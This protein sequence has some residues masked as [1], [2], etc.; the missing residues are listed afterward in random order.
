M[1]RM[2]AQPMQALPVAPGSH[3]PLRRYVRHPR[4]IVSLV[5]AIIASLLLLAAAVSEVT[6]ALD[7]QRT[8]DVYALALVF[9]PL[10]IWFA[11]GQLWAQQRLSGIKLT[12]EQFPEAY[13]MLVDAAGRSGLSYVPDAYVVLGNGVINA[14]ASGHGLRRFVFINSDLVEVGG[15]A[16][17]PDA[18]R[19]VIAHEVGHIAA[20]HVSY[21]RILGT[22]ASQWIPLVGST[23]SRAQEFT[24][25][26]Y[27]H[28]LAPQGARSAMATLAG[29]KY[30]GRSVDVDAMADRAVTEPGSSSGSPTPSRATRC[31]CGASTHCATGAVPAACSGARRSRGSGA[32]RPRRGRT[33]FLPWSASSRRPSRRTPPRSSRGNPD[34]SHRRGRRSVPCRAR[35]RTVHATMTSGGSLGR[36]SD[37]VAPG[38]SPDVLGSGVGGLGAHSSPVDRTAGDGCDDTRTTLEHRRQHRDP[39]PEHGQTGTDEARRAVAPPGGQHHRAEP[40]TERVGRVERRVVEG[41]GERLTLVRD[42]HQARL[43]QRHD[44]RGQQPQDE[45]HDDGEPERVRRPAEEG[46]EHGD[47]AER[48]DD[49]LE[50]ADAVGDPPAQHHARDH[51]DAVCR[52]HPRD[53]ALVQAGEL[54]HG[55]RDEGVHREHAAEADDA[56]EQGEPDLYTAQRLHLGAHGLVAARRL[57][58][59]EDGDGHD[60]QGRDGADEDVGQVPGEPLAEQRRHGHPDDVRDP[61]AAEDG[62]HRGSTALVRHEGGSHDRADPEEGA[63]REACEEPRRHDGGVAVRREDGEVRDGKE[64][65]QA[66]EQALARDL[67]RGDGDERGPD[68]HAERVGRHVVTGRGDVDT[69]ALGDLRQQTHR[70]ELRGADGE[71][72]HG[73]REDGEGRA[74][75]GGAHRGSPVGVVRS[76]ARVVAPAWWQGGVVRIAV[77]PVSDSNGN[78][79][80]ATVIPMPSTFERLLGRL[81]GIVRGAS[82]PSRSRSRQGSPPS[83]P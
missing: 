13:A 45:D 42:V 61:E 44:D 82:A 5:V 71:T 38:G 50:H 4:E 2:R 11:R 53:V 49:A 40:G 48:A 59:Q 78:G 23:L 83:R 54:G 72:S 18:L 51:A 57:V 16:R 7:E 27:G 24:A 65:H 76:A 64:A 17:E 79:G 14:A 1:A 20:G 74:T 29:G 37:R 28:A 9:A 12:R 15:G 66:H 31:C 10:L 47:E 70:H 73:E 60:G 80:A 56:D 46:Q 34:L 63:V 62:R 32:G 69:G 8:P 75:S 55:R 26:S 58:R 21:W 81:R 30:L 77:D 35:R 22:F 68:D 41:G 25:D 19:F 6:T 36:S 33:P 39:D 52:E 3:L 67:R 43:E